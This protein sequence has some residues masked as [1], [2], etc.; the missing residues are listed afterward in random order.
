M[1]INKN[2]PLT[3]FKL[4]C[5]RNSLN[6]YYHVCNLRSIFIAC[7][8]DKMPSFKEL[9]RLKYTEAG[10]DKKVQIIKEAS[11]KWKDI[12]GIISND[13]NR[14]SVLEQQHPGR[15]EDC[16]RQ[17]LVD[18]FINQKPEDYSQDWRGLI[19]LLDDVDLNA[20]AEKIKYALS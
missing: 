19:E 20:L 7:F 10:E 18:D 4:M 8:T 16:L 13:P 12:A 14:I 9:I 15:P 2:V 17:T 6:R 5:L 11:N 1:G 3:G